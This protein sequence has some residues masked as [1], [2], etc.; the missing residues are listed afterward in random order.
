M[1]DPLDIIR[2]LSDLL[3]EYEWR[4][5]RGDKGWVI[6]CEVCR[7]SFSENDVIDRLVVKEHDKDCRLARRI[8]EAEAFIRAEYAKGRNLNEPQQDV[9]ATEPS[10]SCDS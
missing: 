10:P 8:A 3:Q 9:S 4:A 7:A 5:F 2:N 6:Q 1:T